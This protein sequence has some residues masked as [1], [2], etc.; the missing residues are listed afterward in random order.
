MNQLKVLL[1]DDDP[2]AMDLWEANAQVLRAFF[3]DSQKIETAL[4]G[5]DFEQV[6]ALVLAEYP[7]L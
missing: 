4:T 7:G 1:A 5:Y 3:I 2:A 6:L